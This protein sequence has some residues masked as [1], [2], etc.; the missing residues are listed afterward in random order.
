M[1]GGA[2][3]FTLALV[4]AAGAA[5]GAGQTG[6]VSACFDTSE[7]DLCIRFAAD[8]DDIR[9]SRAETIEREDCERRL[10]SAEGRGVFA[11]ASD[12]RRGADEDARSEPAADADGAGPGDEDE[13]DEVG[14]DA[15]RARFSAAVAARL[16]GEAESLYRRI[17]AVA[18]RQGAR[19]CTAACNAEGQERVRLS[20]ESASLVRRFAA[21]MSASQ[22]GRDARLAR[23]R[24]AGPRWAP[25]ESAEERCRAESDCDAV[26][27]FGFGVCVAEDH[28]GTPPIHAGRASRRSG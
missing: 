22:S 16:R 11:C 10:L 13:A 7:V 4:C 9:Q 26:E 18:G 17:V 14:V 19:A 20:R 27:R 24:G 23:P 3:L 12:A 25:R 2:S 6:G 5:R 21:C 15:L 28:G 1:R 8:I